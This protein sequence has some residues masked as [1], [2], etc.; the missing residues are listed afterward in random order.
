MDREQYLN[1]LNNAI[2]QMNGDFNAN[3]LE[4][5]GMTKNTQSTDCIKES[6]KKLDVIDNYFKQNPEIAKERVLNSPYAKKHC[7]FEI[8]KTILCKRGLQ[9]NLRKIKEQYRES[10]LET[11]ENKKII[12]Q[13][14]EEKFLYPDKAKMFHDKLIE[15]SEKDFNTYKGILKWNQVQ[16]RFCD[17]KIKTASQIISGEKDK[18]LMDVYNELLDESLQTH[19]EVMGQEDIDFN[20]QQAICD[21]KFF[22]TFADVIPNKKTRRGGKKNKKK[23]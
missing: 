23:H 2:E 20:S 9:D 5:Y 18:N 8:K 21:Y 10:A 12:K 16:Q 17:H 22:K 3:V 1:N 13:L 6:I 19:W 15:E 11:I 7:E 4:R 14:E